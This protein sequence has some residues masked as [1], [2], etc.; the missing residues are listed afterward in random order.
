MRKFEVDFNPTPVYRDGRTTSLSYAFLA[1]KESQ[2]YN[3]VVYNGAKLKFYPTAQFWGITN[4]ILGDLNLNPLYDRDDYQGTYP[5]GR[6]QVA[7]VLE[8][9]RTQRG[10]KVVSEEAFDSVINYWSVSRGNSRALH[11]AT[12]NVPSIDAMPAR[13]SSEA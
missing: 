10:T 11:P 5:A 8:R 2:V 3:G 9:I 13:A 12:H 7:Q 1:C 6:A 4:Q